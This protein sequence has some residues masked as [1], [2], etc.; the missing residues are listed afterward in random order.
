MNKVKLATLTKIM[1]QKIGVNNAEIESLIDGID[2]ELDEDI[3][4]ILEQSVNGLY[5]ET[6][7]EKNP[8]VGKK[9]KE[10]I[11]ATTLNGID[12]FVLKDMVSGLDDYSKAEFER[13]KTTDKKIKF[14]FEQAKKDTS[15][16]K[17]GEEE[18]LRAK[19]LEYEQ[20]IENREYVPKSDYE[21]IV[22]KINDLK[23]SNFKKG[24]ISKLSPLV[25]KECS[26][27]DFLTLKI[28]KALNEKGIYFDFD[29]GKYKTKEGTLA[30]KNKDSV[31]PFTDDDFLDLFKN[32][33]ANI[34]KKSDAEPPKGEY[35]ADIDISKIKADTQINDFVESLKKS[36]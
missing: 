6:D 18:S 26:D 7:F 23:S 14:L 19:L 22:G 32:S 25:A 29:E 8:N 24:L 34:L 3:E 21:Q 16:A 20:K 1:L 12:N 31:K 33:N 30:T 5:T 35:K 36:Q 9:A 11:K 17:T 4:G 10:T 27:E 2:I 28:D 15:T 13:L